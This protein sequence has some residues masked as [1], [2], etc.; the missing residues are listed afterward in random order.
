MRISVVIPLYKAEDYIIETLE[1]VIH[2]SYPVDEVLVIDDCG[3]DHSAQ[4]VEEYSRTHQNVRLIRQSYNQG[5][6]AARNRGMI[7][8]KN[9]WVLLVDADDILDLTLVEKQV[10]RLGEG[11]LEAGR[12]ISA[13]HSAYVQIDSN[14]EIVPSSE[15]RGQQLSYQDLFGTL[16]VRN[17]IITPTGLLVNRGIMKEIGGFRVD[18]KISEDFDFYLRLAK[19]GNMLYIDEPLVKHRRHLTNVTENLSKSL[20]AGRVIIRLYPFEEIKEAILRRSYSESKNKMDL[21]KVQFYLGH[22]EQGYNTLLSIEKDENPVSSLFMKSI[23]AIMQ[24]NLELAYTM[25]KQLINLDSGHMAALNNMAVIIAKQGHIKES[26]ELLQQCLQGMPGYLDATHNL[27]VL[28]DTTGQMK[29][30]YTLR[31]LRTHL[32]RYTSL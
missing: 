2:Q 25:L 19:A 29:F 17:F 28:D 6:S 7:E 26:R 23:Y 1:S 18:L 5:G 8:A 24:E 21:A 27:K 14:S 13:I 10:R 12:P 4:L 16:I 30:Q 31:E 22:Y 32:L 20:E 11:P 9:D 3:P 15:I